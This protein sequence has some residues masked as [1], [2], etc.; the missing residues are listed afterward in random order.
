MLI[1]L[2]SSRMLIYIAWCQDNR[3]NNESYPSDRILLIWWAN[4]YLSPSLFGETNVNWIFF[5]SLVPRQHT[6]HVFICWWTIEDSNLKRALLCLKWDWFCDHKT[7]VPYALIHR[8]PVLPATR[9]FIFL[10]RVQGIG[11]SRPLAARGT[12]C[13]QRTLFGHSPNQ[14]PS[15]YP[16]HILLF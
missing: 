16:I 5:T 2:N 4:L 14:L 11:D 6:P 3:Q 1:I 15:C 12:E 9:N 8:R 10:S 7:Y 13:H